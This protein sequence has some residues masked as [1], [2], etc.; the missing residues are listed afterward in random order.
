MNCIAN[1]VKISFPAKNPVIAPLREVHTVDAIK[2]AEGN[3]SET[4]SDATIFSAT[5]ANDGNNGAT[6]KLLFGLKECLKH[7]RARGS[8]VLS[9]LLLATVKQTDFVRSAAAVRHFWFIFRMSLRR[10]LS[11]LA[12]RRGNFGSSPHNGCGAWEQELPGEMVESSN[13][14]GPIIG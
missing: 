11:F 8:F 10:L 9:S 12:A 1:E 5:V 2:V 4:E 14:L 6:D 3:E 7:S 13:R